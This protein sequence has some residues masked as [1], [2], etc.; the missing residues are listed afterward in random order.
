M[1]TGTA[2]LITAI[3]IGSPFGFFRRAAPRSLCTICSQTKSTS[4]KC[5]LKMTLGKEFHRRWFEL[6]P[7]VSN[8]FWFR[9][10]E[11]CCVM[12]Q[13]GF[14][15][16]F[17]L[18]SN[19]TSGWDSAENQR[20]NQINKKGLFKTIF[21]KVVVKFGSLQSTTTHSSADDIRFNPI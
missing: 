4:F 18:H 21:E 14:I 20:T 15:L 9:L 12:T 16:D 5:T 8:D 11:G 6:A 7:K 1:F 13:F 17:F 10:F 3:R 2:W 19:E